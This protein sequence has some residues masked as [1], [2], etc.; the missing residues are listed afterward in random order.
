LHTVPCFKKIVKTCG[1]KDTIEVCEEEQ[2]SPGDELKAGDQISTRYN[3]RLTIILSDGKT[4]RFGH[5]TDLVINSNY[6]DNNFDT[7]VDLGDGRIY[8]NAKPNK[9]IKGIKIN[10]EYGHYITEGTE[11][12]CEVIKEGK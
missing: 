10:T 12:T 8:V 2:L 3:G 6:C 5:N 4:I 11:F 9:N 1:V 7:Q